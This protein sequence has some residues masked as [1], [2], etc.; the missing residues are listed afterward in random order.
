MKARIYQPVPNAMQSGQRAIKWT[1][2]FLPESAPFID[3]RMGW[4]GMKDT[5][6]GEVRL[7]FET[8]E[9][10]IEYAKRN[11]IAFE[12]VLTKAAKP[13]IPNVYAKNF[14]FDAIH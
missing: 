2:E 9:A 13:I 10:A 8:K 14:A 11:N 12:V 4:S 3:P 5:V 7:E 6:S 1:L